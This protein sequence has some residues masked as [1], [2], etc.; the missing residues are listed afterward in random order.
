MKKP[1]C[2][3]CQTKKHMVYGYEG[4]QDYE[5]W[6][7]DRCSRMQRSLGRYQPS[8]YIGKYLT[9]FAEIAAMTEEENNSAAADEIRDAMDFIWNS[10]RDRQGFDH[11]GGEETFRKM[12]EVIN[13]KYSE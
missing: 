8:D 13:A 6:W 3:I 10:L 1:K 2:H 9:L 12:L 11:V 5:S 7:C 4:Y